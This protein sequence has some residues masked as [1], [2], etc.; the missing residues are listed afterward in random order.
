MGMNIEKT[1]TNTHVSKPME[2]ILKTCLPIS[3]TTS[4]SS[5]VSMTSVSAREFQLQF[6]NLCKKNVQLHPNT[7]SRRKN[8]MKTKRHKANQQYYSENNDFDSKQLICDVCD[9]QYHIYCL[10]EPLKDIP[11]GNW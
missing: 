8:H 1:A 6:C 10:K 3:S 5:G 4:S 11:K 2:N 7:V 9:S